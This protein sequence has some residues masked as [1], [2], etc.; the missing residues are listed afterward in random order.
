M[1]KET[2]A[3][4]LAQKYWELA[5]AIVAFS[6]LQMLTFL[7]SFA[8][9]SFR[10]QIAKAFWAVIVAIAASSVLYILGVVA[11]YYAE[12]E[13]GNGAIAT[14]VLNRTMWARIGIIGFYTISGMGLLGFAK[15]RGWGLKKP[16]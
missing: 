2:S 15:R 10:A 4:D 3:I 13:L 7:Y 9:K 14:S 1:L 6:V 16:S 5:N 8:N 11:C 12:I